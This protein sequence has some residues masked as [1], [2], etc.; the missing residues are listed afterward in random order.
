MPILNGFLWEVVEKRAQ[1]GGEG[2]GAPGLFRLEPNFRNAGSKLWPPTILKNSDFGPPLS[3][4]AGAA[5]KG[6]AC[7]QINLG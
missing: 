6:H 4:A 3:P 7:Q 2:P 1:G 5:N